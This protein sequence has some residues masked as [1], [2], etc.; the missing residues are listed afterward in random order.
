MQAQWPEDLKRFGGHLKTN[1]G[2]IFSPRREIFVARA[3]ARLD[4]MAGLSDYAG[5]TV[6]STPLREAALVAVQKRRDRRVVIRNL[7]LNRER[8]LNCEY[9]LD[10]L[11]EDG[12]LKPY[13]L[14]QRQFAQDANNRWLGH[15]V[16]AI[17]VLQHEGFVKQWETGLSI[18]IS[19]TIPPASSAA[20]SAALQVAN[21]LAIKGAFALDLDGF[22]IALACQI[23]ENRIMGMPCGITTHLAVALGQN[24][25]TMVLHCQPHEL[26]KMM[27]LPPEVQWVGIFSGVMSP[28]RESRYRDLRIASFMGRKMILHHSGAS[29]E[30]MRMGYLCNTDPA[31]WEQQLRKQVLMKITGQEFIK[32]FATHDDPATVINLEKRYQPRTATEHH[33]SD[34]A[35]SERCAELL[36]ATLH[37]SQQSLLEAGQLMYESHQS[38]QERCGLGSKETDLL[39]DL[40]KAQ[41]PEKGLYGAKT[42]GWGCGGTVAVLAAKGS[43]DVLQNLIS[44]YRHLTNSEP[45]LFFGSSCGAIEMGVIQMVFD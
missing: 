16:G 4:I 31:Q 25:R 17:A 45:Y 6:L 39:V 20:S 26:V 2:G 32:R 36:D 23:L 12:H 5:A 3:P 35:R 29:D 38:Y 15:V 7:N 30:A 21:M 43:E 40:I 27:S 14:L 1:L 8:V 19:S 10:D 34:H 11:Y 42:T 22:Q 18:A 41:G 37:P 44:R 33:L 24:N 9:R 13:P 28:Q